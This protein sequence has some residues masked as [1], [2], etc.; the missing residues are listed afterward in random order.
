MEGGGGRRER[1]VGESGRE[2]ERVGLCTRYLIKGCVACVREVGVD[3][4]TSE[5]DIDRDILS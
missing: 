2:R 3:T 1:G 4:L 5:K